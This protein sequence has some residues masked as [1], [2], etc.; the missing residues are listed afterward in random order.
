MYDEEFLETMQI[1]L[2][3]LRNFDRYM[4]RKVYAVHEYYF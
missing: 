3:E 1:K 4:E 2:S